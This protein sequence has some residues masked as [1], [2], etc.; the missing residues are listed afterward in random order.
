MYRVYLAAIIGWCSVE[1]GRVLL[2]HPLLIAVGAVAVQLGGLPQAAP[3][4]V[5]AAAA[6]AG[7][8]EEGQ[9]WVGGEVR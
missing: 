6:G 9:W 4:L 5:H 8:A 3:L 7:Q 2:G 1:A